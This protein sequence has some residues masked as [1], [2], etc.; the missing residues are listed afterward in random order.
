MSVRMVRVEHL[1]GAP[2]G[3]RVNISGTRAIYL[4]SRLEV[5][6]RS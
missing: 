4:E 3:E 6:G 2:T 1:R 5:P